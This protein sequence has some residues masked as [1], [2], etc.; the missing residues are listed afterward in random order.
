[1][2]FMQVIL[3]VWRCG[4]DN[5]AVPAIPWCGMQRWL[6]PTS[7]FTGPEARGGL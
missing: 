6:R 1:M 2:Q 7:V 3:S 5:I 4:P